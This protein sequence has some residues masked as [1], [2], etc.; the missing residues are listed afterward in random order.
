MS[1]SYTDDAV[2]STSPT[3]RHLSTVIKRPVVLMSGWTEH[4]EAIC[5][6]LNGL[7]P[8]SAIGAQYGQ[9]YGR[10][11]RVP[12]ELDL[13]N[14]EARAADRYVKSARHAA[15]VGSGAADL[16]AAL[17]GVACP[18]RRSTDEANATQA[19]GIFVAQDGTVRAETKQRGVHWR[20]KIP[21]DKTLALLSWAGKG[22]HT[23]EQVRQKCEELTAVVE[24]VIRLT[25]TEVLSGYDRVK[26]A[27]GLIR[28]LPET[29]DGRNSWLLNYGT[30][31]P[32]Q[33][34]CGKGAQAAEWIEKTEWV[35]TEGLG[36]AG[37]HRADAVRE[38]VLQLRSEVASLKATL[39]TPV[40]LNGETLAA[41]A[42]MQP[43]G[44]LMTF[45]SGRPP[46][47]RV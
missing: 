19:S 18:Q 33:A 30:S 27:E 17:A 41:L 2:V 12:V 38:H 9:W 26:W 20:G 36:L 10:C 11:S 44:L 14:L 35:Q 25:A 21:A 23:V 40:E 5:K 4:A 39:K 13:T 46:L 32:P 29:H 31:E 42:S 34:P 37:Q 47:K 3:G 8:G 43:G 28:Q 22:P 24:P 7:Q 45:G 16:Y 6:V 15:N 1:F